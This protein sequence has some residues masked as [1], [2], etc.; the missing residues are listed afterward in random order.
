MNPAFLGIRTE[1]H[2]VD[3]E[4]PGRFYDDVVE[5]RVYAEQSGGSN[6]ATWQAFKTHE[7]AE[8]FRSR[9]PGFKPPVVL[10]L[11]K[12]WVETEN[13]RYVGVSAK[14]F[15]VKGQTIEA[16]GRLVEWKPGWLAGYKRGP[17]SVQNFVSGQ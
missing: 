14:K 3:G 16:K 12:E 9:I 8:N 2:G 11:Q 15:V 10:V 5:Y 6:V 13:G 1:I 17:A 4:R 7:E